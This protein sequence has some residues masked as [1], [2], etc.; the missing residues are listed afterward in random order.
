MS[1]IF[2]M[3]WFG[4]VVLSTATAVDPMSSTS[5][6]SGFGVQTLFF[7]WFPLACLV[8]VNSLINSNNLREF[9]PGDFNL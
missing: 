3:D 8:M 9:P 2:D 4:T 5:D 1:S 7:S 6:I